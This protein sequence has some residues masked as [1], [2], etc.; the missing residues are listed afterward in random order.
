MKYFNPYS[1]G[2]EQMASVDEDKVETLGDVIQ[3][4]NSA[5]CPHSRTTRD[6]Y[7]RAIRKAAKLRKR[8]VEDLPACSEDFLSHFQNKD[9][10]KAWG[11]SFCAAKRWKRNVAAA[12]NGATGVIAARKERRARADDWKTL[13]QLIEQMLRDKASMPSDFHEKKLISVNSTADIARR[14]EIEPRDIDTELALILF[15]SVTRKGEKDAVAYTMGLLD[16]LR[17]PFDKKLS[18][19]LPEVP[20]HFVRPARATAIKIPIAVSD[21]LDVWVNIASRGEWSITDSKYTGG[22]DPNSYLYAVKKVLSTAVIAGA[23]E[24]ENLNTIASAFNKKT[25]VVVVQTLKTW[26]EQKANGLITPR[27][28]KGYLEALIPF[29]ERNGESSETIKSILRTDEWINSA[30]RGGEKMN[31]KT[32]EFCRNVVTD[33]NVQINFLS[34]HIK[35]RAKA[36]QCLKA[37]MNVVGAEKN[38]LLVKARQFGSC[39]AFAALETEAV[40]ARV[41]NVLN[42]KFRGDDVW[43]NLGHGKSDDGFFTVPAGA[44]K[45]RKSIYAPILAKSPLRGMETLRWFEQAIRPLYPNGSTNDHFFPAIIKNEEPLSYG[46]FKSWW[47][48]CAADCGFPGLNPHMFRHGQASI[49][50]AKNPGNWSLVSARLGDTEAV[51]RSTYV[52]VDHE[53]LVLKGQQL[54]VEGL[55][56]AA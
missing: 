39:A 22:S 45:N 8:E 9:Y 33:K 13:L 6:A 10:Q 41:S 23:L 20:L 24:L 54:L 36:I 48:F 30:V 2:M 4:I 16:Q 25:M 44:V 52:W 40:P 43:L 21:E 19:L 53:N 3:W 1:E 37:A 35:L 55:P 14:L 18:A 47:S 26:H 7:V 56:I 17:N 28:A 34:L 11:K 42:A 29:L 49:L 46:T 5:E 15:K 12:I 32:K 38:G 31:S 50:V 27:T 51:C